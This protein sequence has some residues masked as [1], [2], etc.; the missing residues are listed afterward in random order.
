ML[1]ATTR[2]AVAVVA[3]LLLIGG[4]GALASGGVATGTGLW[5]VVL[6]AG[7][8]IALA[9]ER[10]RYR[11]EDAE[12]SFESTGPGGGEPA[13][14]LDS[15]FRPSEETFVDPTTG[16]TMRVFIDRTTGDRRY[17]ADG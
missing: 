11:S 12:R 14:R 6:G 9:I 16:I 3:T 17:V 7:A 1:S 13:G 8:L 15:R 10:N 2:I 5:M 4:L